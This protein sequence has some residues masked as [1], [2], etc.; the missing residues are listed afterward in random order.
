MASETHHH[1][2]VMSSRM[3]RVLTELGDGWMLQ[4]DA[5]RFASPGYCPP[6]NFPDTTCLVIDQERRQQ[7]LREG[8]HFETDCFLTAT[9]LPQTTLKKVRPWLFEGQTQEEKG[10]AQRALDEFAHA[11]SGLGDRLESLLSMT[12]LNSHAIKDE[13]GF[14][15]VY[16]D[17]LRLM[18]RLITGVDHPF[19]L[20]DIPFY[21][22]DLLCPDG[23]VG[24]LEPRLGQRHIRVVAIEGLPKSSYPGILSGLTH[25][26]MEYRWSTRAIL[27]DRES[28]I[29]I[30]D[31]VR[32]QWEGQVRSFLDKLL[33]R[34]GGSINL[35]AQEM[36]H[37]AEQFRG[38]I[39]SGDVK[40]VHYLSNVVCMDE[41]RERVNASAAVV[42]KT[43]QDLGFGARSEDV[44]AVEAW[45]GTLPADGYRN[46]R[47]SYIHTGNLSDIIPATSIWPGLAENPSPLMPAHSPPLLYAATDGSTRRGPHVPWRPNRRRQIDIAGNHGLSISAIQGCTSLRFRQ[48]IFN[49]RADKSLRR[50][51]L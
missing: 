50:R 4:L 27:I 8:G 46:V 35:Y 42:K 45:L 6:G 12:R 36:A 25:L 26:P 21:L 19:L 18:R 11:V 10:D 47:R 16:D 2:R 29:R 34:Y 9:Y 17:Q 30:C 1:M 14:E 37:D 41:S 20:P 43:I 33:Q 24:G 13:F 38:E 48:E 7:F 40:M 5:I 28:A 31:K 49:V 39:A 32:K 51:V 23:F 3:N 22:N 15:Q 44:N